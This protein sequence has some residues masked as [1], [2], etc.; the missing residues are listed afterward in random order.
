MG[1]RLTSVAATDGKRYRPQRTAE[2]PDRANQLVAATDGKYYCL[3]AALLKCLSRKSMAA[4][5]H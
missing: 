1:C 4:S 5:I 2:L 3:A